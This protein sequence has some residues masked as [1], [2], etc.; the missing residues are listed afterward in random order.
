MEIF[1]SNLKIAKVAA[2]YISEDRSAV[3]NYR[4]ISVMS[5]FQKI[6]E[7][8]Y[9]SICMCIHLILSPKIIYYTLTSLASVKKL[10]IYG[11]F[12]IT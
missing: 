1:L 5:I 9:V 7:K 8:Q 3:D 2:I 6:R 10:N 12:K 4:F 11:N